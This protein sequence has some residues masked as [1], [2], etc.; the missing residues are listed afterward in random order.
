MRSQYPTTTISGSGHTYLAS[1]K[2]HIRHVAG[3]VERF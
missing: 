2:L 3:G 1:E